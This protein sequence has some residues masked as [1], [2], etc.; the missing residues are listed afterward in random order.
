[1]EIWSIDEGTIPNWVKF[2]KTK[3][4]RS[5]TLTM[6]IEENRTDQIKEA[7]I[8]FNGPNNFID[9]LEIIQEGQCTTPLNAD[10]QLTLNKDCDLQT[11]TLDASLSSLERGISLKW[12]NPAGQ[13]I[14][15]DVRIGCN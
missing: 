4:A 2:S 1:M 9:V 5:I 15:S 8:V 11:A 14:S 7:N 6:T 13:E 10:I 3:G 12:F